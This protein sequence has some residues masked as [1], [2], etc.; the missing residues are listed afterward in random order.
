MAELAASELAA[1]ELAAAELAAAEVSLPPAAPQM[2]RLACIL[3]PMITPGQKLMIT[4]KG[5]SIAISVLP[6]CQPNQKICFS[7]PASHLTENPESK[8]LQQNESADNKTQQ[9][10]TRR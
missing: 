2:V 4:Y 9:N 8:H 1:A 3:P 10:S 6:N 5:A 7:V